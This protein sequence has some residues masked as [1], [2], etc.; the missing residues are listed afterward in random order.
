MEEK[1][2]MKKILKIKKTLKLPFKISKDHIS[3]AQEYLDLNQG[4]RITLELLHSHLNQI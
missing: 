3:Q 4:K 1:Q 2:R